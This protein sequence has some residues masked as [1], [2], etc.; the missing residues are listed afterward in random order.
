M[1]RFPKLTPVRSQAVGLRLA[2]LEA[3][4]ITLSL[5]WTPAST[6]EWPVKHK[7]VGNLGV[8]VTRSVGLSAVRDQMAE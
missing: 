2:T 7:V 1:G 6:G 4:D 3:S 8:R 5:E